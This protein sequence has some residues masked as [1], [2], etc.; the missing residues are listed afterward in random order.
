MLGGIPVPTPARVNEQLWAGDH[1]ARYANRTLKPAEIVLLARY[2]RAFSGRVLEAGCG[3]GRIL[4]YL[5]ALGGEVH[6]VDTSDGMLDYCRHAYPEAHLAL[7]DLRNLPATVEGPFDAIVA[8]DNLFDVIDP[9]QR[10]PAIGDIRTLLAPDG[11]LVFSSHN[12]VDVDPGPGGSR[13]GRVSR[14]LSRL[15]GMSTAQMA[16]AVK[17][18]P[19]QMRNRRRLEPL[20]RRAVDYAILNDSEGDYGALHYYVRRDAQERQLDDAGFTLLECLDLQG[21]PVASGTD[22]RG[23]SLYYVARPS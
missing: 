22:G 11:V 7:G 21:L 13:S 12:L 18:L 9:E 8:A 2:H 20:E 16:S 15:A 23:S 6:G 19:R 3:A 4:G 14:V 1:V 17:R 10:R 5:V